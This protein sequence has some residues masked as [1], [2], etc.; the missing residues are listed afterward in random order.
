MRLLRGPGHAVW[1]PPMLLVFT[2]TM[3]SAWELTPTAAQLHHIGWALAAARVGATRASDQSRGGRAGPCHAVTPDSQPGSKAV[4]FGMGRGA[5]FGVLQS[6]GTGP[7]ALPRPHG[8]TP[9]HTG[10]PDEA[11]EGGAA[12]A[13]PRRPSGPG[14]SRSSGIQRR[15]EV[16]ASRPRPVS[17]RTGAAPD[18]PARQAVLGG[19]EGA[20]RSAAPTQEGK[21][22]GG[23]QPGPRMV[24]S[25]LEPRQPG[26]SPLRRSVQPLRRGPRAQPSTPGLLPLPW[27]GETRPPN[28]RSSFPHETSGSTRLPSRAGGQTRLKA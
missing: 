18:H 20:W 17:P 2:V 6:R 14:R 26:P 7:E 4:P 16:R 27:L 24:P 5:Q 3:S 22:S 10:G 21:D 13:A 28:T 25:H 12:T 19:E 23:A 8:C 1:A 11:D 15:Q 9:P